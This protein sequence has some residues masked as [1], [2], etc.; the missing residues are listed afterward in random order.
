VTKFFSTRA[1]PFPL[2]IT[3]IQSIRGITDRRQKKEFLEAAEC[4]QITEKHLTKV[5]EERNYHGPSAHQTPE[6]KNYQRMNVTTP[7]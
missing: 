5:L 1:N 2:A 6:I 3:E 7:D 4:I